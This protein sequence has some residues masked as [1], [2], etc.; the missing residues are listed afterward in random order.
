MT[1]KH[2]QIG[3]PEKQARRTAYQQRLSGNTQHVQE[4]QRRVTGGKIRVNHAATQILGIGRR[5]KKCR[6][7][8]RFTNKSMLVRTT[9]HIRLPWEVLSLI[10]LA[11]TTCWETSWN[12][13]KNATAEIAKNVEYVGGRG[14]ITRNPLVQQIDDGKGLL[15]IAVSSGS[16]QFAQPNN[17]R[18]D[19]K[20]LNQGVEYVLHGMRC[21]YC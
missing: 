6:V 11:S 20:L 19:S 14:V 18:D 4:Q 9:M 5:R 13:Q 10:D 17:W 3:Y 7:G 2:I 15:H 8:S 1:Q 16:E 21:S 12:G